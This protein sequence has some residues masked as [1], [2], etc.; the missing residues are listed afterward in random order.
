MNM[1]KRDEKHNCVLDKCNIIL[2]QKLMKKNP[3]DSEITEFKTIIDIFIIL[4][5]KLHEKYRGGGCGGI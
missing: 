5:S 4:K 3:E 1:H 2:L